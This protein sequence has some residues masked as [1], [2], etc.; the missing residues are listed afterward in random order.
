[1]TYVSSILSGICRLKC[2]QNISG[3]LRII[4]HEPPRFLK[5]WA[6]CGNMSW[7]L[8]EPGIEHIKSMR[9]FTYQSPWPICSM[10]GIIG[11]H[12][13]QICGNTIHGSD[14]WW[15][16]ADDFVEEK[17]QPTW[18][19]SPHRPPLLWPPCATQTF[20]FGMGKSD[21][22]VLGFHDT[23]M[24]QGSTWSSWWFQLL[25]K[26]FVKMEI[27]PRWGWKLK[28]FETTT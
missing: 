2:I 21:P 24:S 16:L 17:M 8:S 7:S 11:L 26:I 1:M 28:R 12:L 14:G 27:F 3:L 9:S 20:G 13:S 18:I 15:F 6:V 22:G 5:C 25:C 23:K 4:F 19:I 10:Y